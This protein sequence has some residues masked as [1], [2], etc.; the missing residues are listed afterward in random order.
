LEKIIIISI[1]TAANTKIGTIT[2]TAPVLIS[3]YVI[4]Y[5]VLYVTKKAINH[6]TTPKKNKKSLKLSSGLL[7]KT[8]LVNL[9]TNLINDSINI[10]WTIRMIILT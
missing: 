1:A 10:L 3:L 4:N 6:R 9:T 5:V 2:A 7:I 8:S